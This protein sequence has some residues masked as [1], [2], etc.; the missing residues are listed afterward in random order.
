MI[1]GRFPANVSFVVE[2]KDVEE[3]SALHRGFFGS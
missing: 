2:E 1:A 3:P